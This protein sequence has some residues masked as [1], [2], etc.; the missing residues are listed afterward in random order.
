[1]PSASDDVV[2]YRVLRRLLAS[3]S[4]DTL[5]ILRAQDSLVFNDK[6]LVSGKEY[7]YSIIAIDKS[8]LK[9]PLSH[10]ATGRIVNNLIKPAIID[11]KVEI[12]RNEKS[13]TLSWN[14]NELNLTKFLIYRSVNDEPLSLYKSVSGNSFS[15]K[16]VNLRMGDNYV[17]RLKA[18]FKNGLES[19]FS[20]PV[21]ITY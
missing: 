19:E 14:Y 13:V 2:A 11:F 6:S 21:L 5:K 9:S 17:Y 12:D 10:P 7:Q 15:W 8:K 3:A 16:D 18:S 20:E 4:W 1:V